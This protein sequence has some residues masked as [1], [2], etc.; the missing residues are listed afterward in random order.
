M[1]KFLVIVLSFS[2]LSSQFSTVFAQET[3]PISV[4]EEMQQGSMNAVVPPDSVLIEDSYR[5]N[6]YNDNMSPQQRFEENP[7]FNVHQYNYK[8]QVIVGGV[9]MFC[10]TLAMV[11]NNNYNPKTLKP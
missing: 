11:A 4:L 10:I 8:Q 1:K 3:E 6:Y 9:I 7:K 2:I 5:S